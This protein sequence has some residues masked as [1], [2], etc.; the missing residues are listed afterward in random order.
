MHHIIMALWSPLLPDA[1]CISELKMAMTT[2]D[3]KAGG[4]D[5]SGGEQARVSVSLAAHN[6]HLLYTSIPLKLIHI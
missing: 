1:S 4:D 5:L 3:V 2:H 6:S